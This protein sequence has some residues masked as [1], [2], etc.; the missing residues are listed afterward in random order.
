M[1]QLRMHLSDVG[2]PNLQR[3]PQRRS[4]AVGRRFPRLGKSGSLRA[5]RL[6]LDEVSH[7][8][9]A[10]S[11][12]PSSYGRHFPSAFAMAWFEPRAAR[13]TRHTAASRRSRASR[14]ALARA[15]VP[16]CHHRCAGM[17]LG[18][19]RWY[20]AARASCCHAGRY[21]S[22]HASVHPSRRHAPSFAINTSRHSDM[23]PPPG[24]TRPSFPRIRQ[25][26]ARDTPHEST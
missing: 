25:D 11:C 6:A 20:G 2:V 18:D 4:R 10:T 19:R 17:P 8:Q 12:G 21:L 23:Q 1:R 3:K 9:A 14:H 13:R 7:E 16:S 24:P 5:P 22:P 26:A 15:V